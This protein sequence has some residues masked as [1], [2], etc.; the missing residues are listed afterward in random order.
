M[1]NNA[2]IAQV[3]NVEFRK[4]TISSN[5]ETPYVVSNVFSGTPFRAQNSHWF[6][7]RFV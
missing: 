6:A 5:L 3:N 2:P 4:W 1:Y 7:P